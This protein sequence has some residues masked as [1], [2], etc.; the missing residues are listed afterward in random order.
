MHNEMAKRF[1]EKRK[2]EVKEEVNDERLYIHLVPHSHDDVGWVKTVDE[3]YSGG[4]NAEG[5]M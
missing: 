5:M 1:K 3:Y 4:N 2:K